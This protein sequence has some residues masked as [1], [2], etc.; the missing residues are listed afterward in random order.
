M[1]TGVLLTGAGVV[2]LMLV[3]RRQYHLARE[4]ARQGRLA[5]A[6]RH[7]RRR[8]LV[9]GTGDGGSPFYSADYAAHRRDH[10]PD[11]GGHHHHSDGVSHTGSDGAG[12]GGAHG[13][14]G[15]GCG[16]S[17]GGGD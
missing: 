5:D 4:A 13:G 7:Q 12:D 6:R 9:A 10:D 1:Q 2:I 16:G 3:L 17:C 11:H 14:C 8:G 15:N